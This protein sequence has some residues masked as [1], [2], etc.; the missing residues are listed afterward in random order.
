MNYIF[1]GN[2]ELLEFQGVLIT[3]TSINAKA[4][5][6]DF[7]MCTLHKMWSLVLAITLLLNF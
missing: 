4:M 7:F 1:L 5:K 3:I 6:F 2:F